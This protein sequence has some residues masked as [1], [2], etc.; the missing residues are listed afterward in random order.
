[1][2]NLLRVG[3]TASIVLRQ[4]STVASKNSW[5]R[6]PAF[7]PYHDVGLSE[8]AISTQQRAPP[9]SARAMRC[10]TYCRFWRR[11]SAAGSSMFFQ[12]P[13]AAMTTCAAAKAG[14]ICRV[15]AVSSTLDAGQYAALEP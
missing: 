6:F 4:F 2:V 10:A 5:L 9:A 1:M 13:T 3:F 12:A 7:G 15:R 8:P 14:T 11:L